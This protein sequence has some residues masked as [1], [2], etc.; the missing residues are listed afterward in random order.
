MTQIVFFLALYEY[1]MYP[2]RMNI[3]EYI[4]SFSDKA[5]AR[6]VL[7]E[8]VGVKEVTVRSWANGNRHPYRKVW[9][10]IV[11]ATNGAVTVSDL[12]CS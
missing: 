9:P 1:K 4:N 2:L 7:A 3:N 8:A 10:D 12:A 6:I 11:K 5:S